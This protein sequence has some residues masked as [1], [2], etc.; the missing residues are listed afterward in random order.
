MVSLSHASQHKSIWVLGVLFMWL[1]FV[2]SPSCCCSFPLAASPPTPPNPPTFV[3]FSGSNGIPWVVLV[4]LLSSFFKAFVRTVY[5]SLSVNERQSRLA[6]SSR[7]STPS[8]V[9]RER[10]RSIVWS[11]DVVSCEHGKRSIRFDRVT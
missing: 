5:L 4:C 3:E 7:L 8:K 6:R 1:L 10:I 11:S 2:R 9:D